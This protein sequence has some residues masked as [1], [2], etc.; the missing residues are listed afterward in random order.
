MLSLEA[1]RRFSRPSFLADCRHTTAR[2][3]RSGNVHQNNTLSLSCLCF[4]TLIWHAQFG[5]SWTQYSVTF[6][7]K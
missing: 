5:I 6:K 1:R 7:L 3:H 4:D 2:Y